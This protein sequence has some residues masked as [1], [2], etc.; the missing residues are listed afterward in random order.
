MSKRRTHERKRPVDEVAH[1]ADESTT[2][3]ERVCPETGD[4][5]R[6]ERR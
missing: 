1:E 4:G 6:T 5:R 3:S 2:S